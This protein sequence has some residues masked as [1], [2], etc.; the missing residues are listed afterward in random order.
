MEAHGLDVENLALPNSWKHGI[1]LLSMFSKPHPNAAVGNEEMFSKGRY[2][3]AELG[4]ICFHFP[5]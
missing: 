5:S 4:S 2:N 3:H 1:V